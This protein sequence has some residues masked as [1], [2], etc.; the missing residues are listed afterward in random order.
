MIINEKR[1][2]KPDMHAKKKS[3]PF[4]NPGIPSKTPL[5]AMH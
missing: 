5:I 4:Y 1:V 3:N 2:T